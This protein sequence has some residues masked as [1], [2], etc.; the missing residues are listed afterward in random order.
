MK[1]KAYK[2]TRKYPCP[3]CDKKMTRGD[4]IDHILDDHEIMIPEGYSAA[5]VVYD[6]INKKDYGTCM[7]CGAKV[8]TWDEN[9]CR[10]KNICDNPK[11][12]EQVK[13]K[14][15]NNHLDDPE[16]QKQ[17]LSGR[18]ISGKYTFADGTSHEY[19]GSYEKK[20][21]E[22]MDK[23]LGIEGKDILTPG[24]TIEYEYDGEKHFWILDILY[25]PAMLAIDVKDGG[26]NPNNRP[27]E[28]Y[29]EKQ[30]AKEDA[31]AKDGRY[32]YLRLT[33]NDF[34]QLLSALADIKFGIIE[35][36]P[37]KGIYINESTLP[38]K[39]GPMVGL[40]SGTAYVIPY[41]AGNVDDCVYTHGY[42][43]GNTEMDKVFHFDKDTDELVYDDAEYFKEANI[44]FDTIYFKKVNKDLLKGRKLTESTLLECLLGFPY[45][46]YTDFAY[47]ENAFR[48]DRV[49][50]TE[51]VNAV[52]LGLIRKFN[53]VH[54]DLVLHEFTA[55]QVGY[56]SIIGDETGYYLT[57][58]N[59]YALKSDKFDTIEDIPD[60]LI[61][62]YNTLYIKNRGLNNDGL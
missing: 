4:L 58:P 53:M 1:R 42:A 43:F 47:S 25:V 27:M 39:E 50:V 44:I 2:T 57:T 40:G 19:V 59:E 30:I 16:K 49:A 46:S 21:L 22:F 5:R 18:R 15:R 32:N 9:I 34:G 37:K 3:F 10:Y 24:P 41:L 35:S 61:K 38:L 6:S 13:S 8:Y 45:T 48:V 51:E 31:I 28:S 17:M 26:S 23:G 20:C 52:R 33:D 60:D 7:V 29:R 12:M 14:A 54:K 11:C 62:L 36:D 56:V 55:K